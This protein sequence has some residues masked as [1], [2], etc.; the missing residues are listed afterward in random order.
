M[1]KNVFRFKPWRTKRTC[2]NISITLIFVFL[3][4]CIRC[5][6]SSTVFP[7]VIHS[8]EVSYLLSLNEITLTEAQFELRKDLAEL[9]LEPITYWVNSRSSAIAFNG[10]IEMWQLNH[11]G[12]TTTR[13]YCY[14]TEGHTELDGIC[15]AAFSL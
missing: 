5:E 13:W 6:L 1:K 9:L 15:C 2:R 8:T 3:F 7:F 11:K 10:I 4:Q 14:N 12:F